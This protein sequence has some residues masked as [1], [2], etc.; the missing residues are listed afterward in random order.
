MSQL[1][2][3]IRAGTAVGWIRLLI[4]SDHQIRFSQHGKPYRAKFAPQ[5]HTGVRYRS[6]ALDGVIYLYH[7]FK[8]GLNKIDMPDLGQA[9]TELFRLHYPFQ[10]MTHEDRLAK[11]D[12]IY[13]DVLSRYNTKHNEAKVRGDFLQVRTVWELCTT[14]LRPFP[15]TLERADYCFACGHCEPTNVPSTRHQT[16]MP[17]DIPEAAREKWTME[18]LLRA[19]FG[20]RSAQFHE[21]HANCEVSDLPRSRSRVALARSIYV[22]SDGLPHTFVLAPRDSYAN[23]RRATAYEMKVP[24]VVRARDPQ[25]E[26]YIEVI[27]SLRW[28]GGVYRRGSDYRVY[29]PDPNFPRTKDDP[30]PPQGLCELLSLYDPKLHGGFEVRELP[31]CHQEYAVPD[32]WADGAELLFY[33]VS[34]PSA[35]AR[36]RFKAA[37]AQIENERNSRTFDYDIAEAR[38]DLQRELRRVSTHADTWRWS[39]LR[40]AERQA[41]QPPA[42]E[43]PVEVKPEQPDRPDTP[44]PGEKRTRSP[45]GKATDGSGAKRVKSEPRSPSPTD[46]HS[47]NTPE[48]HSASLLGDDS[49]PN[50]VR[51]QAADQFLLRFEHESPNAPERRAASRLEDDSPPNTIQR[52]AADQFLFEFEHNSPNPHTPA[53]QIRRP[54]RD[55][56]S[57]ITPPDPTPD[58]RRAAQVVTFLPSGPIRSG[59]RPPPDVNPPYAPPPPLPAFIPIPGVTHQQYPAAPGQAL[60]PPVGTIAPLAPPINRDR[61]N[62]LL[63][64]IGPLNR[65]DRSEDRNIFSEEPDDSRPP[66]D[67]PEAGGS[68]RRRTRT[69]R[70]VEASTRVTYRE[71]ITGGVVEQFEEPAPGASAQEPIVKREYESDEELV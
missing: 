41:Q 25:P 56:G 14:D 1:E 2:A 35:D 47:T 62:P 42:R 66:R 29:L 32:E 68:S 26:R 20:S 70:S 57:G 34:D 69:E 19:T 43:P 18:Q 48:R 21:Q 13:N 22:F 17:L 24:C 10:D 61:P 65:R 37:R 46:R 53:A 44:R 12:L 6:T 11:R 55:H 49:P 39:Q 52:Q 58:V 15:F 71:V 27:A 23:V 30:E 50:T 9:E 36:N 31:P 28:M 51:R 45:D 4:T 3:A 5:R 54:R 16:F 40:R 38:K 60:P 67:T 7:Y 33:R 8:L 59:E 64:G 63:P